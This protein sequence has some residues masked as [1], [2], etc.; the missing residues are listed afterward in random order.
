MCVLKC[1]K[2]INSCDCTEADKDMVRWIDNWELGWNLYI[3]EREM[4]CVSLV[5]NYYSIQRSVPDCTEADND[6]VRWIDNWELGW[7]LYIWGRKIFCVSLVANYYIIREFV[8]CQQS[9]VMLNSL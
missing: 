9:S 3:W 5:A 2:E 4:F 7:D 6:M 1:G 8:A